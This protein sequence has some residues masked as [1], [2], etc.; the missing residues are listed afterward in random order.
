MILVQGANVKI[1]SSFFSHFNEPYYSQECLVDNVFNIHVL[2]EIIHEEIYSLFIIYSY[3]V[4][5][6]LTLY[7]T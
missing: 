7:T 6:I 4:K 1:D 5:N 2:Y 3:I